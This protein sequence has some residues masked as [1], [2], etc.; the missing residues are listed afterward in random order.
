MSIYMYIHTYIYICVCVCV[1]TAVLESAT[2]ARNVYSFEKSVNAST[3]TRTVVP[4]LTHGGKK[5]TGKRSGFSGPTV[6]DML[7][8]V[9]ARRLKPS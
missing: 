7:V 5:A 3:R 4:V 6:T 2:L 9:G 1:C 8:T